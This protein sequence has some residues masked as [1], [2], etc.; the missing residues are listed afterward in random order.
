MPFL[1]TYMPDAI[2]GYPCVSTPR[3]RT[4]IQSTFGGNENRNQEWEHPL[5]RFTMPE[6]V[7]TWS[8]VEN[9]GKMW[10]ITAGPYK[11]FAWRDPLDK[12]SC[13]LLAA[14]ELDEDVI[15]RLSKTDQAIGFGDGFT[16]TF[17]LI[18]TYSYSGE[19]YDRTIHLP[20]L[21][22]VLVADN[23]VLVDDTTYS[24]SRPGGEITFD[25]PPA[26]GHAITAG[27]LFDCEVRFESDDAFEA[28][29]RTWQMG[30]FS[31]LTL[32]EV[33]PC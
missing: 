24:V 21:D 9:L 27:F 3:T 15:A 31:D 10:R 7:R 19:T 6:G 5:H 4:T 16:D 12:A 17:Q 11:S 26:D 32:V 28:M 8:V 22:T 25:T 13:D 33:R 20:V 30:G 29:V 18:K 1:D 2:P 23:G 14:N